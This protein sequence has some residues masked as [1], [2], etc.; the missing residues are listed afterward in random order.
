MAK[1][2]KVSQ[3]KPNP[4]IVESSSGTERLTDLY[5]RYKDVL[6]YVVVGI[7]IVFVLAALMIYNNHS[8]EQ[9]AS[10]LY[11]QASVLYTKSI[12]S[13]EAGSGE[14]ETDEGD[15]GMKAIEKFDEIVDNFPNTS[16]ATGALLLKGATYINQGE[17][18]KAA[19]AYETFINDHEDHQ[20]IPFA[21]MGLATAK[22][23]TGDI[24]E[25]HQILDRIVTDFPDFQ[26]LDIITFEIGKRF[27]AEQNWDKARTAYQK[28][29]DDYPE[30]N[31]NTLAKSQLS[32]LDKDH[33]AVTEESESVES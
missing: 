18:G 12:S 24:E 30:S 23:N 10:L 16:S 31:W 6:V 14:T 27:E 13:N 25:S 4:Q 29:L 33:P 26:L 5:S 17:N 11:Q 15:Q 7:L 9:Q 28:V 1:S 32:K 3:Q 19:E 21:K 22:F 20:L 8:K 2:K